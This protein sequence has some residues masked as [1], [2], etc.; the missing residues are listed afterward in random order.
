MADFLPLVDWATFDHRPIDPAVRRG[1][2]VL[3]PGLAGDC[4]AAL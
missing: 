1:V 3:V 2:T 4:Q